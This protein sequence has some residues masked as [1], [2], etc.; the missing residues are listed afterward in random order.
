MNNKDKKNKDI[1]IKNSSAFHDYKFSHGDIIEAGIALEGYEIKSVV[2]AHISFQGA[3]CKV[4]DKN[5]VFLVNL[6]IKR[7]ENGMCRDNLDEYRDRRLLLNKFQ[8]QKIA[9]KVREKGF[10]LVPLNIHMSKGGSVINKNGESVSKKKNVI[11]ADI[12]LAEGAKKYDKR[13]AIKKRDT[14]R[15]AKASFKRNNR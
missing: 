4:T 10:T 2:A 8:I 5:E 14:E 15:E 9:K 13:E 12:V 6:Y 1:Y 7:Y 3:Y 11:K